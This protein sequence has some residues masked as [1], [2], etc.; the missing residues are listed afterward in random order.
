MRFIARLDVKNGQLIKT[1]NLEGLRQLGNCKEYALSYYENNIDELFLSD[2]VAS[3]YG[4]DP[5]YSLLDEITDDIFIPI[6]IS[7]GIKTIKDIRK[8]LLIG[9]DKVAINTN[10]I[11]NPEFINESVSIFGSQSVAISIQAKFIDNNWYCYTNCG[12]DNSGKKLDL[13][14]N[15]IQKRGVGEIILTSANKEGLNGGLDIKLI[16]FVKNLIKVP[17]TISGGFGKLEHLDEIIKFKDILSG[18][19]IAGSLHYK[20]FTINQIKNHCKTVGIKTREI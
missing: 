13:W 20:K 3:L 14:I 17:V 15:E 4:R 6:T 12:R 16:D 8:L 2:P 19:A 5:L 9:A 11:L 7:G 18:I 10:A 1:I